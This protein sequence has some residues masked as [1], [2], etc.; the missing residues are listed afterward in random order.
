MTASTIYKRR[1]PHSTQ[2]LP[3]TPAHLPQANLARRNAASYASPPPASPLLPSGPLLI[4]L[5]ISFCLLRRSDPRTPGREGAGRG[6]EERREGGKEEKKRENRQCII[7]GGDGGSGCMNK[8]KEG[9]TAAWLTG[10]EIQRNMC[11][12]EGYI[13]K[14]MKIS[15]NAEYILLRDQVFTGEE[16]GD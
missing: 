11:N 5:R 1:R 7:C 2:Y 4:L 9:T 8:D 14:V 12:K 6:R 3:P 16:A 10:D 15:W 13:H